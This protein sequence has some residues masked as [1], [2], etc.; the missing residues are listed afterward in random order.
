[1]IATGVIRNMYKG[2]VVMG[3]V[4]T[5]TWSSDP[6][7]VSDLLVDLVDISDFDDAPTVDMPR[8]GPRNVLDLANVDPDIQDGS[9]AGVITSAPRVGACSPRI[10]LTSS[11]V[12]QP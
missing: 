4:M 1:M 12:E 8:P 3:L 11:T 5:A 6:D 2:S 9:D 7:I 10:S